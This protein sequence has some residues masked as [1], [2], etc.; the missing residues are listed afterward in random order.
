MKNLILVIIFLGVALVVGVLV[1]NAFGSLVTGNP[2]LS[3]IAQAIGAPAPNSSDGAI[4]DTQSQIDAALGHGST[5]P[6]I[7]AQDIEPLSPHK[8]EVFIAH[9]RDGIEYTLDS[10]IEYITLYASTDNT[11]PVSISGWHLQSMVSGNDAI[12]PDGTTTFALGAEP[13]LTPITLAPGEYAVVSTN[14]SPFH[15]SFRT[16][17]CI[18]YLD[19]YTTLAPR[20]LHECINPSFFMPATL[21]NIKTYGESCVEF[22]SHLAPCTYITAKTPGV[23]SLDPTCRAHLAQSLTYNSCVAAMQNDPSFSTNSE[24]RIYLGGTRRLWKQGYEA[25]RL[26]DDQGKTVDVYTY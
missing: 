26:L 13:E 24:W 17:S 25:I 8:G 14:P 1:W 5:P 2:T 9:D 6:I 4:F 23:E 11:A 18:G 16:N 19:T 22:A 21:E 10:Q 15:V 20:V 7:S 12:I 3:R